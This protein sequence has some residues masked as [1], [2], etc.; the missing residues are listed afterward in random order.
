MGEAL[1]DRDAPDVAARARTFTI[2]AT[3]DAY[4]AQLKTREAR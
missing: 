2:Q 4:L 1:D 3:A